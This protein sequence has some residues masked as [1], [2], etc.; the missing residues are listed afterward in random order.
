MERENRDDRLAAVEEEFA[1]YTVYDEHYEKIGKV[2]DL[3]VDE[4]D[5]PEYLGVKMGLLG[6][7]STLIPWELARVNERRQLIE[8]GAPKDR[9]KDAP[10]FD[11]DE[12]IS[13]E[14]EER[15]YRH[16][17]LQRGADER[18]GYGAYYRDEDHSSSP[19]ATG[20]V[21][22]EERRSEDHYGERR[23]DDMATGGVERGRGEYHDRPD[24]DH[25]D[26]DHP[27]RDRTDRDRTASP[28]RTDA[29]ARDTG[30]SRDSRGAR[31]DDVAD[32]DELRVQRSE[33]ELRVGT[34]EHEAGS[35]NVR[36]RVRTEREQVR[37]PRK[38]EEV[39][40]E[41]VPVEGRERASE[42]EIGDDEIRVPVIEEEIVVEKRPVVKEELRIRK[43]VVEEEEIV[44][45]DVRKEEVEIDDETTGRGGRP[46]ET[47]GRGGRSG[48]TTGRDNDAPRDETRRRDR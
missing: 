16:F 19:A 35:V 25:P 22:D 26:R 29:T 6:L 21:T 36:K 37:V 10:T 39:H 13:P 41:R 31:G 20:G 17:G 33:E 11:D 7:K 15:V 1:G 5:R 9:I 32:E 44:E 40:V 24:R 12:E 18:S 23:S 27:D 48:G 28:D 47:T 8:V 4:N 42:D 30:D 38:R 3:F 46:D 34:R 45:E 43:D 2:D 14:L